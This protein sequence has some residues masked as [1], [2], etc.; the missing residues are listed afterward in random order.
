MYSS[1]MSNKNFAKVHLLKCIYVLLIVS[2]LKFVITI[3]NV[4]LELWLMKI[5]KSMVE[6]S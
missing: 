3:N 1:M 4:N 6:L 5:E 2:L